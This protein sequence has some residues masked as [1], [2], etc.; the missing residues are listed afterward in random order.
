MRAFGKHI[1]KKS[2]E[3]RGF[4]YRACLVLAWL[5]WPISCRA[6]GTRRRV[7]TRRI[8]QGMRNK[9]ERDKEEDHTIQFP[10]RRQVQSPVYDK[11]CTQ[12][13]DWHRHYKTALKE[14]GCSPYISHPKIQ[15][16][17][18]E[19]TMEHCSENSRTTCSK[20]PLV[21][22]RSSCVLALSCQPRWLFASPGGCV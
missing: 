4:V 10:S 20:T 16:I 21:A 7:I 17:S 1:F 6:W 18:R 5:G 12:T 22:G 3:W 11:C 9:E 14:E 13:I 19:Q 15:S 2:F 8:L